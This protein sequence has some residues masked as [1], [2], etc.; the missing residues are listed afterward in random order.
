[1]PDDIDAMREEIKALRKEN[2]ALG[3]KLKENE[4]LISSYE[5]YTIFQNNIYETK[6]KQNEEQH[7]YLRLILSNTPDVIMVM[8]TSL[9]HI[10]STKKTMSRLGINPDALTGKNFSEIISAIMPEAEA[11]VFKDAILDSI[12]T[13]KPKRYSKYSLNINGIHYYFEINIVA[14]KNT[15]DTVI[16]AMFMLHNETELQEAL[17]TAEKSNRAKSTFLAKMSHEIRTPM[18][19]IIGMS[20]LILRERT[21]GLVQ[22]HALSIKQAGANLM[23]IINDILDFS[24]IESG[25]FEITPAKYSFTT[26][27]NDII[28]IIRMRVLDKQVLFVTTIDSDIPN[29][30]IGDEIRIRQII[31]N[32]LSNACK[33][34]DNGYISIFI[35]GEMIAENE[36]LLNIEVSD[37]GIGIKKEDVNKLFGDFVQLDMITNRGVEG[38]GLGLV[39]TKGLCVAMGGDITLYSTYGRGSTF[40]VK[41]PQTFEVYEPF[42]AVISPDNIDVLIYEPRDAYA[43]SIIYSLDSLGVECTLVTDQSMFLNEFH[44]DTYSHVFVASFLFDSTDKVVKHS[45]SDIIIVLLG[46]Y[47]ESAINTKTVKTLEMP[48]HAVS[49]ANLLNGAVDTGYKENVIDDIR[50]IAPA[51]RVLV[52]DDLVTNLRVAEGLLLPY[53]MKIDVCQSGEDSIRLV[54]NNR[55][56]I[57]FMDH[58]MPEMD[59][60]EATLKIR[61]LEGDYYK[62]L[63]IIALT[64][65][66][67]SGV[68]EMFL[69]N[70]FNDFLAK[71]I[72]LIKLYAIL[73]AWLPAEKREVYVEKGEKRET[74]SFTIDGIDVKTGIYMTGGSEETYLRALSA[75]YKDGLEKLG[76]LAD[77]CKAEDTGL[78][79]TYTHAL[80]SASGSIGATKISNFAKALE[81][82]GKNEDIEYIK[83]NN[84][85]FL[86]ELKALLDNIGAVLEA[87]RKPEAI[88]NTALLKD[89]V[90]KLKD[91]LNNLDMAEIDKCVSG[92]QAEQWDDKTN[93]ALEDIMNQ[94][95]ISEYD[96]ALD[97]ADRLIG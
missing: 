11:A 47:G 94:I 65:N 78:Y 2:R 96:I 73:E 58:M 38:T 41:I 34:C 49:I 71:P 8:D 9:Q 85:I 25:K 92:L 50:F 14:F 22:E 90:K 42:A 51:A 20:E 60:V 19:A 5:Q 40:T 81:I 89:G 23:A 33:F 13:G 86:T 29:A 62:N 32:L 74:I 37:T 27:I 66:A 4:Y 45:G 15:D 95:L 63:P 93:S 24:K 91:A 69:K 36:V 30:M 79:A 12:D 77:C 31:L 75:Y 64:A 18:N 46:E 67:V 88:T 83:N 84:G 43:N 57:V 21:T 7:A 17:E 35:S 82:A 80:K 48:V 97:L 1:M 28:S 55:Y 26:M 54:Q 10:I 87:K 61:E 39:I 52:V 76:Q 6:K 53:R 59:G 70:G 68:K 44:K 56:D 16:G 3:R 72:E